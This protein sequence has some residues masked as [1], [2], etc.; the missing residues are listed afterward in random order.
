VCTGHKYDLLRPAE[1]DRIEALAL[2]G[3]SGGRA[4]REF[5]IWALKHNYACYTR[6]EIDSVNCSYIQDMVHCP[7]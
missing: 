5:C 2:K 3:G 4:Y 7:G 6:G 1:R